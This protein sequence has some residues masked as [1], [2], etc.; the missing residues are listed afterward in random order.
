MVAY[1]EPVAHDASCDYCCGRRPTAPL[2][3]PVDAVYC[4]SLQEQPHRTRQAS[5][6]FHQIGLCRHIKFYRPVRGAHSERAIWESHRA[7]A[8][9]AVAKG[10]QGAL[11]LEDDVFFRRSWDLLAPK[12][13]RAIAS[14]PEQW[15]CFFLGHLPYQG[16]FVRHNVM[17]VRSTCLHAYIAAP[18]L[19]AFIAATEPLDP[20]VPI[21]EFCLGSIDGVVS[22]L[23]NIYA[24]FPMVALQRFA[25]DY[26][27]DPFVDAKGRRRPWHDGRRWRYFFILYGAQLMQALAVMLSPFHRLTLEAY[28]RQVENQRHRDARMIQQA[29]FRDDGY[30]LEQRPD[31]AALNLDPLEHY[32]RHGCEE[33]HRPY[34]LFDPDFYAAQ[35]AGLGE[36]VPLVHYIRVGAST[37]LNPHPL[38]DTGYYLSRYADRIPPGMNPLAHYMAD[39]GGSGLD[40][41]PLFDSAWYL[42]CYPEVQ[43]ARQNPLAHY[44]TAGWRQGF[45]PHPQFDG[46]LYLAQN[47][48]VAAAG[49]N[50]LEHF[51]KHGQAEGRVR[52]ARKI[53]V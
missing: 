10:S 42:S 26:R 36:E 24:L 52:P 7:V 38:F 1:F 22:S 14:L 4:I 28:C 53:T 5:E 32:L 8:Q 13:E 6:H 27:I 31:V 2:P 40:P 25:G 33:G 51:A 9:D 15:Q 48:D 41:H 50:P 39:G 45:A 3:S 18:S 16:Y 35:C 30:Y 34:L 47:P 20:A 23:P 43:Q 12:V 46:E 49:I 37:N 17:R 19:L 21:W 29:G 11:I 44:L